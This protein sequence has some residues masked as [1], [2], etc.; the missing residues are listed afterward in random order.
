MKT[1]LLIAALCLSLLTV[2]AQQKPQQWEYKIVYQCDEKKANSAAS[3]GWEL[4][5]ISMAS[6][7]SIGVGTCAFKRSR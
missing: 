3:E 4:V 5:N 1:K 6:Y 7:G 2:S